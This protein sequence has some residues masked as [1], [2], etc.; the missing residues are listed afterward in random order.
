V[1]LDQLIEH[2]EAVRER[3]GG[4]LTVMVGQRNPDDD[5]I[6][7]GVNVEASNINETASH[8]PMLSALKKVPSSSGWLW[9]EF[10]KGGIEH[11][12][13]KPRGPFERTDVE[14][15]AQ[16][17][18]QALAVNE[19]VQRHLQGGSMAVSEEDLKRC[20]NRLVDAKAELARLSSDHPLLKT[21]AKRR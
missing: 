6:W 2:L 11:R 18:E 20:Q 7:S 12:R 17:V 13:R 9:F 14:R 8:D 4:G 10:P 1:N 16:E 15:A 3:H 5:A 19:S 21:K